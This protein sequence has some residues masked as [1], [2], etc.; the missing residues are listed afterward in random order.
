MS[1]NKLFLIFLII[2]LNAG[3][4]K[5][6]DNREINITKNYLN[7]PVSNDAPMVRMQIKTADQLF[8]VFDIQLA[9]TDPQYWVF[10]DVRALKGQTIHLSLKDYNAVHMGIE[11][12]YQD[13]RIAGEDSL[14]KEKLRP[15]FH[16]TTRRG[17]NNDPNG[18]VYYKNEYHL[19]YQHNPYS[20]KWGNMHWGQ[21][22]STDLIHWEELGEA[23]YSQEKY[24]IFSGSAVVD[25]N[26]SSGFQSGNEKVLVAAYTAHWDDGKSKSFQEQH[27]AY[28]N[29]RGRTWKIYEKNPVI[30]AQEEKWNTRYN[31]DPK[32][33]WYQPGGH[34]VMALYEQ[35]GISIYTS[36]NLKDWVYQSRSEG[37]YECPELFELAVEGDPD[38][39]KWVMYGGSGSYVIGD[40]D[41]KK[42][43]W[44]SG[45]YWYTEGSLYAAQ[46]YNNIPD[47]DGRRI[48]MGWGRIEFPG[49]PFNQM[50]LFPTEFSLRT[51]ANGLRLFCEPV[52]EIEKLHVKRHYWQ[53][54]PLDDMNEKLKSFEGELLHIKC[55]LK[56]VD[57]QKFGM[58]V[59]GNRLIYD[60]GNGNLFNGFPY[61]GVPNSKSLYLEVLVDR[62]SIETFLD[63]GAFCS[64]MAKD[65]ESEDKGIQFWSV[66]RTPTIFIRNLEVFEL[67]SIWE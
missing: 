40:F 24:M 11:A 50:M 63:Y 45:K 43:I 17:W 23:L 27:I 59:H 47:S 39:T 34:W 49:M 21:A 22:I 19:F 54:L 7:L 58:I 61:S 6:D 36:D 48:Q 8:R 46:T 56:T 64:V 12:I 30:G 60:I 37:F 14:Y 38:N 66:G 13:D 31:R 55:E 25:H 53:N 62:T 42:F 35:I 67:K 9:E 15:Q 5:A 44:E 16:F 4:I 10:V 51:T 18:L 52:K 57:S 41:G 2:G 3:S 1:S 32:I 29:D 33:F 28:S 20:T 26:N 65:L